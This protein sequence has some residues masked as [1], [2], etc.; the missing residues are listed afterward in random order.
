VSQESGLTLLSK[1]ACRALPGGGRAHCSARSRRGR[2]EADGGSWRRRCSRR[3]CR[4]CRFGTRMPLA[5]MIPIGN[6]LIVSAPAPSAAK[7][8]VRAVSTGTAI[9]PRDHACAAS[10]GSLWGE[11]K[12][13]H[14]DRG[15]PVCLAA[16][17]HGARTDGR[18]RAEA[19][20]QTPDAVQGRWRIEG[21]SIER[22]PTAIKGLPT[23]ARAG[24][25]GLVKARRQRS[26]SA[27]AQVSAGAAPA[28]RS[29]RPAAVGACPWAVGLAVRRRGVPRGRRDRRGGAD[30]CGRG[31]GLNHGRCRHCLTAVAKRGDRPSRWRPF[32]PAPRPA[33][34]QDGVDRSDIRPCPGPPPFL[35]RPRRR[36][37]P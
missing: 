31:I 6:I 11:R 36:P 9:S 18:A 22:M 24:G 21:A 16:G 8:S 13:A 27:A 7:A 12:K 17:R 20:H 37:M 25:L 35:R 5:P 19:L 30:L 1:D 32:V 10:A 26:T 14:T 4:P 28:G 29:R 15:R 23:P 2:P 3:R 33:V 34:A